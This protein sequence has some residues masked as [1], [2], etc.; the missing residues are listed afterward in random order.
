MAVCY[1]YPVRSLQAY[2]N[3]VACKSDF[4]TSQWN[5]NANRN[6]HL[7]RRARKVTAQAKCSEF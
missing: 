3:T 5:P 1:E 6:T 2:D 7:I 4:S